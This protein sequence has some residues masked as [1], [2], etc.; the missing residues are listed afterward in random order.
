VP[1]LPGGAPVPVTVT[2]GDI[3]LAN[4]ILPA[5]AWSSSGSWANP[6][7]ELRTLAGEPLTP[8]QVM[9]VYRAA[10]AE[11]GKQQGSLIDGLGGLVNTATLGLVSFGDPTP[12]ATRAASSPR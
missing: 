4:G 9:A 5:V 2:A 7:A 11:A 12:P 10:Q 6:G 1:R 8:G 3:S